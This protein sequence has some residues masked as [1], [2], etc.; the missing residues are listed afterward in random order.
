MTALVEREWAVFRRGDLREDQLRFLRNGLRAL[1]NPKTAQPFT[2]DEIRRA[3]TPGG[4]FYI[5]ADAVDL[6]A[7]GIQKRAEFLAQQMRID[8]CGS[9]VLQNYHGPM[10]KQDYLPATG[11]SGSVLAIG[12]TGTSWI[13]S[14]TIPDPFATFG[15]DSASNRYQVLVTGTADSDGNATLLLVGIDTGEATNLEAGSDII[16]ANAP[17]GSQPT[18]VVGQDDFSGGGPAE[19]DAEFSRRLLARVR[20]KPGSGNESQLRD[21]A[22]LSSNA[23]EDAY[24]YPCALNAGSTLVS[25]TQKRRSSGPTA[26]LPSAGALAAVTAALVPPGSANVPARVYVAVLAPVSYPGDVTVQA[27]LRPGSAVGWTDL[28]PFPP[29]HGSGAAV[30]ITLVTNQQNFRITTDAAGQ[31]PNAVSG[32]LAGVHL[33][34]WDVPSSRWEVLSVTTVEDLGAGVYR[35]ILASPP[36]HTLAVG[37]C[38]SPGMLQKQA[39]VFASSA[40]A[41]FDSL[42]PGEVINLSANTLAVRAFRRPIPTEERPQR[43]GQQLLQFLSDGLGAALTDAAI[44]SQSVATPPVP[45]DPI[46]GPNLLTLG[47]FAVYPID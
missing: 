30:A 15:L 8:R 42:G 26:R 1:L 6:I 11:G 22:R 25:I 39:D 32:P 35:V 14:T 12:L 41:F 40:E 18:C 31:L 36:A 43:I 46:D 37:D 17:P 45:S 21:L 47:K 3:T 16:W 20:R 29:I 24:I 28:Q 27:A 23:V 33:M 9:A 7:Q 34:V 4:R 10:W 2:E 5:E 19:S 44:A 38:V 13:G